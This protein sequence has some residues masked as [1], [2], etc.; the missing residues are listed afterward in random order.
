MVLASRAEAPLLEAA[1]ECRERGAASAMVVAVDVRDPV[2]VQGCVDDIVGRYGR[3][4]AA[5]H[6]AGVVAYGR[7]DDVPPDVF[8]G[9]VQTNVLGSANVARAVLAQLRRQETGSLIL[10]G[11]VLGH[12]AVPHMSAY[13]VSK[14][15][16]RCLARELQLENRDQPGINICYVAPGSVDTPIYLQAANYAGRVGRPPPPVVSPEKVARRVVTLLDRPRRRVDVG[17][18]NKAMRFGFSFL[19]HVY[20]VVVGPLFAVS[21]RDQQPTLPTAG[22]VLAAQPDGDRLHGGQGSSILAIGRELGSQVRQGLNASRGRRRAG[23]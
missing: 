8:D 15:A 21:A 4:D 14:W 1:D 12:I 13:T 18:A 10:L 5:V 16:V 22:N 2:R 6:S 20:D 9:V 7:F 17:I 11:S 19:P 23:R 3:L